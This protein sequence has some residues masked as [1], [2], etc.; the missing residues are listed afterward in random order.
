VLTGAFLQQQQKRFLLTGSIVELG[1]RYNCYNKRKRMVLK[2]VSTYKGIKIVSDGQCFYT[3]GLISLIGN[4]LRL[5]N[6]PEDGVDILKYVLDYV[7]DYNFE[8]KPNQTI[9]YHSWI[10][11]FNQVSNGYLD[12]WEATSD[13]TGFKKGV[14]TALKVVKE[15]TKLCQHHNVAPIFPTFNQ[16][17]VISDGVLEGKEV[18]AVRYPSPEHMSGWWLTTDLY[19]GDVDTL[20][21]IHYYHVAFERPNL[22]KYLALTFGFRFYKG[23]KEEEVWFDGEILKEK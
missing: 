22:I 1:S 13:G 20:K 23:D 8:I 11:M 12:I 18:E 2:M 19:D 10:L 9:A 17:I 3:E 16:N 7:L 14:N 5:S 15:Q 6:Q 21:V 4:E